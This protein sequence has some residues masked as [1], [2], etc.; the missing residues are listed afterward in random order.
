MGGVIPPPPPSMLPESRRDQEEG[1]ELD[2]HEEVNSFAGPGE[3]NL[4][5]GRWCWTLKRAQ[6]RSRAGR[7]SRALKVGLLLLRL[8]LNSC[9]TDIV[10]VTLLRTAVETAIAWY[11]SCYVTQ[12]RGDKALIFLLFWHPRSS[13]GACDGRA[14]TLSLPPPPPQP[15]TPHP[16]PSPSLI[17]NLAS[18][19]V[20]QDVYL[21]SMLAS[22]IG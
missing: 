14:F 22:M 20:K 19:D 17:S 7:W 3:I 18:V 6:K 12:S 16:L 4:R 21:T 9:A 5:G 2:S 8:F 11:T 15:P 1:G 13:V 10:L